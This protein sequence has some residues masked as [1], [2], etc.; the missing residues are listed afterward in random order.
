MATP[1]TKLHESFIKELHKKFEDGEPSDFLTTQLEHKDETW[2]YKT[3]LAGQENK[4][5][6][7]GKNGWILAKSTIEKQKG[8]RDFLK[9][10]NAIP[11]QPRMP[12][13]P[14]VV[15]RQPLEN[16][17][18][19]IFKGNLGFVGLCFVVEVLVL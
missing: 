18:M 6:L 13:E 14:T 1:L 11:S 8:G 16:I 17:E 3:E 5:K 9:A 7:T 15:L 4:V 10:L 2:F 12:L 19:D